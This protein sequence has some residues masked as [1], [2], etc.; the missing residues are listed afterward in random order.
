MRWKKI[1]ELPDEY[2]K[3]LVDSPGF[4]RANDLLGELL[5][6]LSPD[7]PTGQRIM[8]SIE[9][10]FD[11][12]TNALGGP[13]NAVDNIVDG[14]ENMI[15]LVADIIPDLKLMGQILM[16]SAETVADI[17]RGA[18]L[19]LAIQGGD[20]AG[21]AAIIKEQAGAAMVRKAREF[22]EQ[23][24][25]SE[26]AKRAGEFAGAFFGSGG[27]LPSARAEKTDPHWGDAP[28]VHVHVHGDHK[29]PEEAGRKAGRAAA[30][31]LARARRH[32]GG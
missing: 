20:K 5:E 30:R 7:S 32:G 23:N 1:T 22:G 14:I 24:E 21:A 29:D 16:S 31:E 27:I 17:I 8:A 28:D 25:K 2:Y 6:K 19:F 26:N 10:A 4:H 9:K 15:G 13:E 18:R 3:K 12:I 11:K